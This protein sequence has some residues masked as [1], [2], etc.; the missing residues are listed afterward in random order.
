MTT[1]VEVL[2]VDALNSG[3]GL[4]VLKHPDQDTLE[5]FLDVPAGSP[6]KPKPVRFV[7]VER[8]GGAERDLVDR[9]VLAV[10]FWAEDRLAASQGAHALALLLEALPVRVPLLGRC[11][12]ESIYNFPSGRQARYQL[13]VAATTVRD[14]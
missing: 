9:P 11:R 1:N 2:I 5:A 7:T 4:Q 8:T 6:T 10:Q 13:V 3:L 14:T 12:V